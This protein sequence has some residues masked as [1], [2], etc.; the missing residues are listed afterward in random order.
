MARKRYEVVS[1]ECK[2]ELPIVIYEPERLNVR[3]Y[4]A[5]EQYAD[6]QL[7]MLKEQLK[8]KSFFG[9]LFSN[10]RTIKFEAKNV[11]INEQQLNQLGI[12]MKERDSKKSTSL[13]AMKSINKVLEIPSLGQSNRV[14]PGL[15]SV[16]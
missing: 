3:P 6:Q 14:R 9:S 7:D 1:K 16:F 8:A 11:V 15:P 10:K 5:T 4:T 2:K 12:I 13:E